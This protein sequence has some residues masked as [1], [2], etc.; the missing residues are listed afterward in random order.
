MWVA[1]G[2]C[3]NWLMEKVLVEQVHQIFPNILYS[4]L[5]ALLGMFIIKNFPFYEQLM[6]DL[7][8]VL[9]TGFVLGQS[10][11]ERSTEFSKN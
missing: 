1:V 7:W 4:Y 6:L 9:K 3:S 8:F 11:W 10:D 2:A 5:I